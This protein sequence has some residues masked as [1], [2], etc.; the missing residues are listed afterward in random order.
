M[1]IIPAKAQDETRIKAF[2]SD[3]HLPSN[4]LSTAHLA[5]F[6]VTKEAGRIV[7]S[8]GLEVCGEFGLL[9]SLALSESLRGQGVGGQLVEHIEA[10]ALSQQIEFLYLLTT[11]ADRFFARIGYQT[12]PRE[13]AP[14]ALQITVEFQRICPD[15]GICMFKKLDTSRRENHAS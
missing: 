7:G 11:T 4:D 13:S 12:T 14:A 1:Q 8:V 6:F 5:H 9:R 10:Y 2:L 15:S 3:C